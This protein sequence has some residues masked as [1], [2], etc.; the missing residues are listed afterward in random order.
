VRTDM[1][2]GHVDRNPLGD[3]AAAVA[4]IVCTTPGLDVR[5]RLVVGD[6]EVEIDSLDARRGCPATPRGDLAAARKI[7]L[8]IV[9]AICALGMSA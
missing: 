5:C 4:S 8:K 2:L 7:S 3:I 1:R 9:A 6:R